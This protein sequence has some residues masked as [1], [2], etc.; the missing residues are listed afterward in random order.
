ML[1][2]IDG[3]YKDS[4]DPTRG[5]SVTVAVKEATGPAW[6]DVDSSDYT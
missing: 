1:F 4:S 6:L 2:G 5:S 3:K